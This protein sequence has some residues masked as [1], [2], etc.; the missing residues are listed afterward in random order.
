M[1]TAKAISERYHDIAEATDDLDREIAGNDGRYD[2][3]AEMFRAFVVDRLPA[4]VPKTTWDAFIDELDAIE[5]GD[6]TAELDAFNAFATERQTAG[7]RTFRDFETLTE[8]AGVR[9]DLRRE[10]LKIAG[11]QIE[12]AGTAALT[13]WFD[14]ARRY[15]VPGSRRYTWNFLIDTM[16]A[17]EMMS[18][19][20]YLGL[21]EAQRKPGAA[22]PPEKVFHTTLVNE[23]QIE[24]GSEKTY[25]QR[26]EA[27]KAALADGSAA[28]DATSQL[29]GARFVFGEYR[30]LLRG[31]AELKGGRIVDYLEDN[32]APDAQW[33]PAKASKGTTALTRLSDSDD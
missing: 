12:G 33:V 28:A 31:I 20:E 14:V 27:L 8:W 7:D 24:L 22:L 13:L 21:T 26:I 11:R 9:R 10:Q 2:D 30:A 15:Y 16:D 25:V 4:L 17:T 3:L 23:V 19:E 18:R 5:A 32:G 29:A 1:G 6:A